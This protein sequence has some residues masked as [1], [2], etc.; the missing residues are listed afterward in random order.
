MFAI[1]GVGKPFN[2]SLICAPFLEIKDTDEEGQTRSALIPVSDEGFL[3][4]YNEN[5]EKLHSRF[6]SWR[7]NVLKVAIKELTI[8][9]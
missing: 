2:G 5:R 1:H 4:F 3:F 8:N 9:I 7:E 6:V